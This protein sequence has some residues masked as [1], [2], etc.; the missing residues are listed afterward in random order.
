[1]T[2]QI[3][4]ILICLLG[5]AFFSASETA[6]N[7]ANE[8]QLEKKADNGFINK[9]AYKISQSYN[10]ALTSILIGN[11]IVNFTLS[12][13]ST[14]LSLALLVETG[15]TG[16]NSAAA[17]ATAVTTIVVLIFG[18]IAPK[19]VAKGNSK[20][21]IRLFAIP[22]YF[23][24]VIFSPVAYLINLLIKLVDKIY[25][26]KESSV[27]TD[28]LASIIETGEEEGSID[29][30]RSELLQSA[31]DFNE[32]SIKEIMIPRVD[33]IAV[34]I[35][36]GIDEILETIN[37]AP[38][39]R[40]PVYEESIDNIIGILVVQNLFRLLVDTPKEEIDLRS[41]LV[42][43]YYIHMTVK[44]PDAL[45]VLREERTHIMIVLDEFGGTMGIATMEDILEELV[46]EIW[47]EDEEAEHDIIKAG[48]DKYS[49]EGDMNIFDFFEA[50]DFDEGDF[51]SEYTTVGG[52]AIEMLEGF[53]EEGASFSYE[54]LT[55][56]IEKIE[57]HRITKLTATISPIQEEEE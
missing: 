38:Y 40:I 13:V 14:S 30:E 4:V 42:E 32:T 27:T 51:E 6:Y 52:W 44:L 33:M 41:L 21:L 43:P 10:F 34:D 39:S 48:P 35:N 36:D 23:F 22:L 31:I 49:V 8:S 24:M 7:L 50:I 16:E 54:N 17:I 9:L 1:M 46:G 57:D 55:V 47:D 53:P 45:D 26:N 20:L 12:S 37:T 3:I 28:E 15:I 5:S 11:N 25:V 56:T 19:V 2:V 18:E 29:E